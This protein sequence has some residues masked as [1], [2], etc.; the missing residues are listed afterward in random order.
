MKIPTK[1][2]VNLHARDRTELLAS[3]NDTRDKHGKNKNQ[4]QVLITI[5]FTILLMKGLLCKFLL[6]I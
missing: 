5:L 4:I 3:K 2:A 6:L 1:A